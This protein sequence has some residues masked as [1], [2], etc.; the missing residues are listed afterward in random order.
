MKRALIFLLIGFSTTVFGQRLQFNNEPVDTLF[1]RSH[2]SAYQ[3]DD[4]GT[5][6]GKTD[7]ISF[8]YNQAQNRYIVDRCFG[9]TY[10]RSFR[11]DTLRLKVKTYRSVVGRPLDIA[12]AEALLTALTTPL[13]THQLY[14]QVDTA[15]LKTYLTD[16]HIRKIAKLYQVNW[17]FNPRYSSREQN[18]VFFESCRSMDTLAAYLVE[19]FD[20]PDYPMVT[21]YAN[22]IWLWVSTP[23]AEYR[24][25]GKH[26]NP[27]KQPWYN[28][29]DT[30]QFFAKPVLN[31]DINSSVY[32]LLPKRFLLRRSISTEALAEDYITWYLERR[33]KLF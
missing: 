12:K 19:Q 10:E 33:G 15:E 32:D 11:P 4:K 2:I 31:L 30:T 27:V 16:K 23:T 24:F 22:T 6:K 20:V 5:T 25:E 3:F 26:P 18:H 13:N 14:P 7:H 17:Q 1:I 29:G 9:H 28:H 21:D 8:S